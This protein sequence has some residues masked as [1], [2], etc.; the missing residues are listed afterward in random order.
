[1]SA[2]GL[3]RIGDFSRASSL[4]VK[5]L[6]SYHEA[7]L[8]VPTVV[9]PRT[10]YRSY[11]VAQLTDAAI[12]RRLRLL[13]V[14]L[15][16][17]R[18]VL[19]A[20]DPDVT[21]KVLGDHGAVLQERLVSMQRSIDEL[22]G[23]LDTPALHTPVHRR[24]EPAATVLTVTGTVS[25]ATWVDFLDR[26]CASLTEAVGEA[27]AV[28]VGSF[29]GCYPTLLD[30]DVQEVVAFLPVAIPPLLPAPSRSAGVQVGELPATDVA[31]I[32]HHG[33]YDDMDDT[34]RHLGAWVA[35]HADPADFPV[36]ELY[37]VGRA[38][39]D[40]PERLRTELCWPVRGA[41]V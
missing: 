10:G 17:I 18:E 13:D 14:P 38:E 1:M 32:A 33:A 12:I 11:S 36:R 29:G 3:L 30:D 27:G 35:E 16:A 26:A 8:L 7:G 31:V 23:A 20:R 2:D 6:R 25:E 39:T 15:E 19:S 9:D 37:L 40:D 21:K 34:Y 24:H 28:A 4:S 5:A 22:Q 41:D